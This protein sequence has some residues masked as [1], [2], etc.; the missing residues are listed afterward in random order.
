MKIVLFA[1]LHL[2]SQLSSAQEKSF[3][4]SGK[5]KGLDAKKMYIGFKD[6]TV[7]GGT[8]RDSITVIN[9]S[10][11]YTGVIKEITM[12]SIS[13]NVE[14]VVK[15]T[16]R[17]YF[18]AK[19]S[20]LQF[21]ASP[22]GHIKFSGKITDFVDAYPFGD[23][24][25]KDLAKLNKSVFPLMNKSV[26]LSLKIANKVVTDS[27]EIRSINKSIKEFDEKIVG[28]KEK[29]VRDNPSSIAAVWLLG[30]MMIRSQV[31]NEIATELFGK[32]NK[33][34]LVAIPFYTEVAKRVDGISSTFTGKT[35][36]GIS[37]DNT[38]DGKRF[39]LASLKGKYVVL[40]FW[41]TW[42]GPCIAGMPKMKEYLTRYN[43]KMEIVGVAQES[44]DGT[45]WKKFLNDKPE[46]QWH[47]VLS[48]KDE[49]YILK[50]SVAGFPTKIIVDPEGKIIGRFIGEDDE[51][52][53]KL[54]EL[55]KSNY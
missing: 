53:K 18:P 6:Q 14:R 42:C 11:S 16:G 8:R 33:E 22:G 25:N 31:S 50:F 32:M 12:F 4:L 10:F 7:K 52:Y 20:L 5:I 29:F 2:I 23:D 28:I 49:D 30:D 40:D 54:D 37:S 51:I 45:R 15:K 21:I 27:I 38:Y 48:R 1:F 36:P 26:N 41:G 24:A 39:D 35:V 43:D 46:Y 47:H 9:K 3:M 19:S 17:G 34:K 44:D 55:L 13:P